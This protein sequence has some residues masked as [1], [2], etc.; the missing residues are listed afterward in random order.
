MKFSFKGS[1]CGESYCHAAGYDVGSIGALHGGRG[2]RDGDRTE[3]QSAAADPYSHRKV[4]GIWRTLFSSD[5][6]QFRDCGLGGGAQ[7]CETDFS[8][9]NI[10]YHR[11]DYQFHVAIFID[12]GDAGAGRKFAID[13]DSF[14]R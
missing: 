1:V 12:R 13:L 11:I 10:V 6:F 9:G 2:A 7:I 8:R 5:G 3:V 4:S 14:S